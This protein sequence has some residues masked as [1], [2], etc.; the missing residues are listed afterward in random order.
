MPDNTSKFY[1]RDFRLPHKAGLQQARLKFQGYVRFIINRAILDVDYARGLNIGS[2]VESLIRTASLPEVKFKTDIKNQYNRKKIIN[3]GVDYTPV[4]IKL[5]DTAWNETLDLIMR[6]YAYNYMNVRNFDTSRNDLKY[7][8]SSNAE[9]I[10]SVFRTESFNSN[11]T[12]YNL[13]NSRYFFERIDYVL[14]SGQVGVQYSIFNPVLSGFSTGEI[15]YS[16]SDPLEFD[17]TFDYENFTVV[18]N[19]NFD[20][21]NQDLSK[22]EDVSYANQMQNG[23]LESPDTGKI[24]RS[25]AGLGSPKNRSPQPSNVAAY[26]PTI[27]EAPVKATQDT[28]AT[29]AQLTNTDGGTP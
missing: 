24:Q 16:S 18:S 6:Y 15:D 14:Y 4:T 2:G 27:T 28:T 22:F 25:V 1:L 12:G 19:L 29:S 17:L 9:N 13:N 3:T 11:L 20:L 5:L 26:D 8:L 21:N 10:N 23:F 7:Q